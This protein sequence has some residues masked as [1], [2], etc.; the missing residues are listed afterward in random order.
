MAGVGFELKKMF[1]N[2]TKGTNIRGYLVSSLVTAGPTVICIS[3]ILFMKYFL[4]LQ[5]EI[6][7]NIEL[8]IS[9]MVYCYTFSL[10][11]TGGVSF[12]VVRYISDCFYNGKISRILPSFFGVL[13]ITIGIVNLAVIPFLYKAP[14]PLNIK[15]ITYI[16][17]VELCIIWT[18]S[19]YIT[20]I[21]DYMG[22]LLGFLL[23]AFVIFIGMISFRGVGILSPVMKAFI[24]ISIGFLFTI[25]FFLYKMIKYYGAK[26]F[27]VKY[28]FHFITIIDEKKRLIFIGVFYYLGIFIHNIIFWFSQEGNIIAGTYRMAAFYDVPIFYAMLSVIPATVMFVVKMETS[29]YDKYRRFFALIKNDGSIAEISNSKKEMIATLYNELRYIMMAQIIITFISMFLGV[30]FLPRIGASLLTVDIF[31]IVTLAAY[32]QS[33]LF[34][35][36]VILLYFDEIKGATMISVLFFVL[37]TV[38]TFITLLMGTDYYGYGFFAATVITLLFA[39]KRLNY[40]INRIDYYIF[41][42]QPVY[43]KD[44]NGIFTKIYNRIWPS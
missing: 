42:K 39:F 19:S 2:E 44:K 26:E 33:I 27:D 29:F 32:C 21:K 36:M 43:K 28:V 10:I 5:G 40:Y 11:V 20:G 25:I 15:I 23:S 14:L 34:I 41:S 30:V 1:K 22:I 3:L 38:L 8:F 4:Q 18:F 31:M 35:I 6:Y 17:F 7:T 13:I 24:W 12:L 37:V 9:T 16:I